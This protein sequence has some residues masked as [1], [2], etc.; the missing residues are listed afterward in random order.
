MEKIE[1]RV[2]PVTRYVVTRF[3]DSGDA[4]EASGSEPRGAFDN[5]DIAY[6]VAYALCNQEHEHLG[7]NRE[8]LQMIY[9]EMPVLETA[10]RIA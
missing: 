10:K 5:A 2:R 6:Q 8:G 3:R 9:P 4:R 1:Y 7:R